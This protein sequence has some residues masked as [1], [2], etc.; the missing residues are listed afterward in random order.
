M[1]PNQKQKNAF[2]AVIVAC[3]MDITIGSIFLY[4]SIF[5]NATVGAAIPSTGFTAADNA[6]LAGIHANVNTAFSL[7]GITLVVIGAAGIIMILLSST[8]PRAI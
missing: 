7:G 1:S 6:T 2:M 4:I 3:A 5:V 8:T